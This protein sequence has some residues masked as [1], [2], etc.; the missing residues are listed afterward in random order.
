MDSTRSGQT[1]KFYFSTI[2]I[3]SLASHHITCI[4]FVLLS[5]EARAC[6]V[7]QA[8]AC[9]WREPCPVVHPTHPAVLT[10]TPVLARALPAERAGGAGGGG[11][12]RGG[13]PGRAAE[14]AAG[15]A[16]RA[17]HLPSESGLCWRRDLR[18]PAS[19][20]AGNTAAC[21]C[22]L[23]GCLATRAY[24]PPA[25]GCCCCVRAVGHGRRAHRAR[26]ERACG[27][28]EPHAA[29]R[30]RRTERRGVCAAGGVL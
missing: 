10:L 24:P 5:A 11:S 27:S 18:E 26:P 2:D 28:V 17:Y 1:S 9:A 8:V 7:V 23:P 25:H 29:G 15:G 30:Q 14:P 20:A 22:S 13:L 16:A 12:I 6:C 21:A 3:T 4:T 19:P